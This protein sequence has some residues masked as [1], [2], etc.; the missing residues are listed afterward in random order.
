MMRIFNIRRITTISYFMLFWVSFLFRNVGLV[1]QV[2]PRT[3]YTR[4]LPKADAHFN[5][6]RLSW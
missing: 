3:L 1:P 4:K 2:P 5:E 6:C